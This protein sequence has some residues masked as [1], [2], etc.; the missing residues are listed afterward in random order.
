MLTDAMRPAPIGTAARRKNCCTGTF[1]PRS[2]PP[3]SGPSIEPKRPIPSAQPT[4]LDRNDVGYSRPEAAL[5]PNWAPRVQNPDSIT[6][7]AIVNAAGATCHVRARSGAAEAS[8]AISKPSATIARNDQASRF[9]LKR[10]NFCP[11]INSSSCSTWLT[12]PLRLRRLDPTQ[13]TI[14]DDRRSSTHDL[15]PTSAQ[16]PR[17]S[18]VACRGGGPRRHTAGRDEVYSGCPIRPDH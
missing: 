6:A 10:P 17:Q 3:T 12:A 1:R 8:P 18:C 11:F 14:A 13:H 15:D 4:P 7:D 5:L 2:I 16:Y 9:M